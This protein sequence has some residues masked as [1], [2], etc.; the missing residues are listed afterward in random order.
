[1]CGTD[2]P[3]LIHG[4][5]G[6]VKVYGEFIWV[7]LPQEVEAII[8]ALLLFLFSNF[9]KHALSSIVTWQEKNGLWQPTDLHLK[10]NFIIF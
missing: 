6:N 7:C 5:R 4:T 8:S 2:V 1:M 9:L 3:C 10:P